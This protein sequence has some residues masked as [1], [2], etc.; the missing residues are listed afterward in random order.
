M[1]LEIAG[2][3]GRRA[4]RPLQRALEM[5]PSHRTGGSDED[6]HSAGSQL[7]PVPGLAVRRGRGGTAR[8]DI[9]R[10]VVVDPPD[11]DVDG[12]VERLIPDKIQEAAEREGVARTR[13][14]R[15]GLRTEHDD[16]VE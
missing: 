10:V 12:A 1:T 9:R 16:V 11:V 14:E 3:E 13:D 2:D 6:R 15:R 5:H 4:V 7:G 8:A